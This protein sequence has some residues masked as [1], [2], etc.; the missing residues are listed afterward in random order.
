M[1]MVSIP[2]FSAVQSVSIP[3]DY[4]SFAVV[5]S[6]K[7]KGKSCQLELLSNTSVLKA[8]SIWSGGSF[9]SSDKHSKLRTFLVKS[10][11]ASSLQS[12][13][14]TW[15]GPDDGS[16]TE[17]E[18]E[19]EEEEEEHDLGFQSEWEED[20]EKRAPAANAGD[21]QKST[22]NELEEQLVKEVEQLLEVEERAILQQHA[23]PN[24]EKL[25]T[26]KWSPLHTLSLSGLVTFM[27]KLLEDGVD[28]NRFDNDGVTALHT[29]I[30]GKKEAVISHLLRKGASPHVRDRDGAAPLHYAIHVGT[31][32]IVK[33]LIKYK[34]D[35]NIA[36]NDGWTPLHVAV[37]SRNRDIVKLLLVNGADKSRRNKDG[38][39]PIDLGLCY[40]KDFKSYDLTKLLKTVPMDRDF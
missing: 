40:G 20:E 2:A 10:N 33:L 34:V 3:R 8:Y 19:E 21:V 37:Q 13:V 25:S 31:K 6:L 35:V 28:I 32:R 4:H 1:G 26:A 9:S 12:R 39:T 5:N 24:M 27:D 11:Q 22:T 17:S 15:E 18:E 29:A 36:D 38:R 30:I 7:A 23:A 16:G 14:G